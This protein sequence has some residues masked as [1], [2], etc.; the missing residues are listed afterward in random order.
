MEKDDIQNNLLIFKDLLSFLLKHK[1]SDIGSSILS[2]CQKYV[3][4]TDHDFN[5]T[6]VLESILISFIDGHA[7][8]V[9]VENVLTCFFTNQSFKL[10]NFL[11]EDDSE[12]TRS[13]TGLIKQSF[14]VAEIYSIKS[15]G[16]LSFESVQQIISFLENQSSIAETDLISTI[17]C[18][19]EFN[20][21]HVELEFSLISEINCLL[22]ASNL[23]I[24]S[25][26][27]FTMISSAFQLIE[28]FTPADEWQKACNLIL[29]Q[30]ICFSS[31]IWNFYDDYQRKLC[32]SGAT[33][34]VG[35]LKKASLSETAL[36]EFITV[37]PNKK[38]DLTQFEEEE[39]G[40]EITKNNIENIHQD[41]NIL[42]IIQ[43]I[44]E[45]FGAQ[46]DSV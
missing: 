24:S 32:Q 5:S 2:L 18:M 33:A 26:G 44:A 41:L 14:I 3:A 25:E 31:P 1:I 21:K 15:F 16:M 46:Y 34:I 39:D 38:W 40:E 19:F 11:L 29:D 12:R 17:I 10:K 37:I 13:I 36:L 23:L 8:C 9:L 45:C 35:L 7:D 30:L 6:R 20:L 43:Q 22:N 42:E 4:L 27:A 28:E